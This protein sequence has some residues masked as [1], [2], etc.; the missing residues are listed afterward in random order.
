[1]ISHLPKSLNAVGRMQWEK[2]FHKWIQK[3]GLDLQCS[4]N[5]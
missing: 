3:A 5:K 4:N 1:M 2:I